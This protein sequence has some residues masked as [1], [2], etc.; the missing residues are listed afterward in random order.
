MAPSKRK[1]L[2]VTVSTKPETWS[3]PS[4]PLYCYVGEK[5][6]Y[7]HDKQV[8]DPARIEF[9]CRLRNEAMTQALAQYPDATHILNIE[10]FYLEQVSPIMHLFS[11][12]ESIDDDNVIVGSPIW[13]LRKN[14]LIDNRPTFYDGWGFPE[15]GGLRKGDLKPN[16]S[17]IQVSAVASCFIFPSWVW[18]KFGFRNPEPF[19]EAGFFYTWL[20]RKSELPVLV[21]LAASVYRD[22]TTRPELNYPFSKRLRVTVGYWRRRLLGQQTIA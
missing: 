7:D 6:V 14:R 3:I 15:L 12:Y 9:L 8:K 18:K 13:A 4:I 16:P 22:S 21:D 17:L 11:T 20:C 2:A 5:R 19:P 10:S 1:Y